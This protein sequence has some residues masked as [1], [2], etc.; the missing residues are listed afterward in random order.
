VLIRLPDFRVVGEPVYGSPT[1]GRRCPRRS[2][3]PARCRS[4]RNHRT[5]D[6]LRALDVDLQLGTAATALDVDAREVVVGEDRLPHGALV[7][8]TGTTARRLPGRVSRP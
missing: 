8:A 4:R 3:P 6:E 1:T 5:E 2:W 7:L